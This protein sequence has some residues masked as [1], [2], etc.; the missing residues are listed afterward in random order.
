M[1]MNK[2]KNL[3]FL[4]FA[5][6]CPAGVYAQQA[7][8]I[9]NGETR[10]LTASSSG[11]AS[12]QWYKNGIALNGAVDSTLTVS[13]AA[14]FTVRSTSATGCPSFFSDNIIVQIKA[15]NTLNDSVTVDTAT[16]IPVL[17]N[18]STYCSPFDLATLSIVQYPL[19]GMVSILANG[20]FLYVPNPGTSGTDSFQYAINDLSG[21][22]SNQATVYITLETLPLFINLHRFT[23]DLVNRNVWLQW[24]CEK[25]ELL[26]RIEIE[27][28]ANGT[29]WSIIGIRMPGNTG[30]YSF[31]DYL[32]PFGPQFYRLK[33]RSVDGAYVYSDVRQVFIPGDKDE[34]RVYPN[35]AD[36]E[37]T[38]EIPYN[39]GSFIQLIDDA[40]KV[41]KAINTHEH[42][43]RLDLG[44]FPSGAY[45][46]R[47][48]DRN[49]SS[50]SYKINKI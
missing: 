19:K 13:E 49:G 7:V 46:L 2:N 24:T 4:L 9:C 6:L 17:L 39:T 10:L 16:Q 30:D 5:V 28:S 23:A 48:T 50:K 43:I 33:L 22:T 12:Y 36:Q 29:Q 38:I 18:D 3:V 25:S 21:N 37:V 47:L 41:L 20:I 44:A 11:A 35:P 26:S 34:V 15:P 45:M 1:L 14:T 8:Y 31:L 32:P 27:R 40:G 42:Y